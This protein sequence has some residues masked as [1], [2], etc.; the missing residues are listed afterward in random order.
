[1]NGKYLV[2]KKA[3]ADL[4]N[5]ESIFNSGPCQ[6]TPIEKLVKAV[7]EYRDAVTSLAED[8]SAHVGDAD[9]LQIELFHAL[10][11]YKESKESK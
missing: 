1:M 4:V 11:E 8:F 3:W 5:F 7:E 6:H 10:D 2:F 9:K